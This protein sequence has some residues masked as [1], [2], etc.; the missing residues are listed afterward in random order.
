MKWEV[1]NTAN[2]NNEFVIREII[3][4][5]KIDWTNLDAL[6]PDTSYFGLDTAETKF[7]ILEDNWIRLRL[8][9]FSIESGCVDLKYNFND[10]KSEFIGLT[11]YT[12]NPWKYNWDNIKGDWNFHNIQL[13]KDVGIKYW[14]FCCESNGAPF[15]ELNLINYN[16]K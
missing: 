8:S 13:Q 15:L 10:N 12:D 11:N 7:N 2:N 9:F 3:K 4:G 1:I 16:I 6:N 5:K 14:K